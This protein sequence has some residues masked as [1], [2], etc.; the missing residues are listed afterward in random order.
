MRF[1]WPAQAGSRSLSFW[2]FPVEVFGGGPDTTDLGASSRA[3][4]SRQ[5]STS[6]RSVVS[7]PRRRAIPAERQR[8]G[9]PPFAARA[10]ARAARW[11]PSVSG[12]VWQVAPLPKAMPTAPLATTRSGWSK[13]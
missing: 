8:S 11:P 2:V 6:S 10:A 13:K 1:C 3:R 5:D 4:C 9:W 7:R 12:E